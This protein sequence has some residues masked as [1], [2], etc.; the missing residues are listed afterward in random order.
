LNVLGVSVSLPVTDERYLTGGGVFLAETAEALFPWLFTLVF[1]VGV[2]F[3]SGLV[4]GRSAR[5]TAA[6]GAA[7]ERLSH[8]A[9][10]LVHV[11]VALVLSK[12][13]H[14]QFSKVAGAVH[15]LLP[16]TAMSRRDALGAWI[17]EDVRNHGHEREG[18]YSVLA[19][20]V[21]ATAAALWLFRGRP[22]ALP[23]A[24]PVL[25][26]YL[27]FLLAF[28]LLL[29]PVN[30]AVLEWDGQY[31]VVE[32]RTEP[33]IPGLEG[34]AF[35]LLTTD[36]QMVLYARGRI[37][38]VAKA[39]VKMTS[40]YCRANVLNDETCPA[41]GA[42]DDKREA[43][44]TGAPPPKPRLEAATSAAPVDAGASDAAVVDDAGRGERGKPGL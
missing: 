28:E 27:A 14:V 7:R 21:L 1:A 18:L 43:D 40:S 16:D 34:R 15:L 35:L 30:Y 36:K 10:I 33:P 22:P 26:W 25:R 39:S 23:A 38:D 12:A 11:V 42:L 6:L 2:L 24:H 17:L 3:L 8:P 4:L 31:P 37:V 41:T 20:I 9:M 13:A 32:V 44:A 19:L 29:L 5:L